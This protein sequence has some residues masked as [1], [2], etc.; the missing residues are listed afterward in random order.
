LAN[1]FLLEEIGKEINGLA[2]DLRQAGK[3]LSL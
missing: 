1:I 2:K 3:Y